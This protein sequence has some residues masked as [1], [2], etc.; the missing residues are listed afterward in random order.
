MRVECQKKKTGSIIDKPDFSGGIFDRQNVYC[1]RQSFVS[2][3]SDQESKMTK[4]DSHFHP[5]LI[6]RAA[7]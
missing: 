3:F 1:R 6:L 2:F 7:P 4:N 5:N